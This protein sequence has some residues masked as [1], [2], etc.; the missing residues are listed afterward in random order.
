MNYEKRHA[1]N[2][3]GVP[4]DNNNNIAKIK[5]SEKNN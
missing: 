2:A 4:A 5:K 3:W 1:I